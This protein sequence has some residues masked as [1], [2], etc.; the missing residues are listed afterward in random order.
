MSCFNE[1]WLY[2]QTL[3]SARNKDRHTS[4]KLKSTEMTSEYCSVNVFVWRA[5]DKCCRESL[6]NVSGRLPSTSHEEN[7]KQGA[8]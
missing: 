8:G 5:K 4:N 1:V 3:S 6:V 2:V 7:D